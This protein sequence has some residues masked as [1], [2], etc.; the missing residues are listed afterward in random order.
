MPTGLTALA[1]IYLKSLVK[2]EV[3]ARRSPDVRPPE[4]LTAGSR[5]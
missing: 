4:G 2:A 3:S 5:S 1:G